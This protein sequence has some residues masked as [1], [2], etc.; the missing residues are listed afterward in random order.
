MIRR[1]VSRQAPIISVRQFSAGYDGRLLLHD[2]SFDVFAGEV[3]VI[4]GGSGSGKSTL[5]K[6]MIGLHRPVSGSIRIEDKDIVTAEG[7]QRLVTTKYSLV[8][9]FFLQHPLIGRHALLSCQGG[10]LWPRRFIYPYNG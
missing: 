9:A 5:L 8:S 3:F 6:H 1:T 7:R 10:R 2:I 4:L